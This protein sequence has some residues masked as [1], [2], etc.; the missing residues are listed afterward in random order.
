M[1]DW[2]AKEG[3]VEGIGGHGSFGLG[4]LWWWWGEFRGWMVL[5][6]WAVELLP[7]Q[8]VRFSVVACRCG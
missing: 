1:E 5:L 8:D 7:W 6:W 2:G 3:E 4:A